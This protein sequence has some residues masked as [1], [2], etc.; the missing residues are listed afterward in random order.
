MNDIRPASYS[1]TGPLCPQPEMR[2]ITPRR[3][4]CV[5]IKLKAANMKRLASLTALGAGALSATVAT[6]D[7]SSIVYSGI[8]N[9]RVGF[10]NGSLWGATVSGPDGAG[11]LMQ[12]FSRSA[13]Q[14]SVIDGVSLIAR[15]GPHGTRFRF[16]GNYKGPHIFRNFASGFP[17]NDGW[18][19]A[20]PGHRILSGGLVAIYK[21]SYGSVRGKEFTGLDNP[22]L[23]FEFTG[24]NLS[25][26][27]YGWAQ[28]DVTFNKRFPRSPA[29]TLVDWAYDTSGNQ[30]P[31]GD[32]G[33]PEPSTL[34]LTGLA[35]LALGAKGLR[36]WRVARKSAE[37]A[38]LSAAE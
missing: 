9:E 2:I 33:T 32:T 1:A 5:R 34:T 36:S 17:I 18:S 22:F 6:A 27:I 11:F 37:V 21:Y 4:N 23:L 26:T 31:A 12:D 13:P 7:A 38:V 35:A 16:L 24:G 28:L 14:H 10:N 29:V 25:Q 3:E 19:A 20:A 15:S 30:I 8:L